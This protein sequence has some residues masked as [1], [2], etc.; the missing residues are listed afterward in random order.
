[1]GLDLARLILVGLLESRLDIS[2]ALYQRFEFSNPS[3]QEAQVDDT[4]LERIASVPQLLVILDLT[5]VHLV[6]AFKVGPQ[7]VN[8]VEVNLL[9]CLQVT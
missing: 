2:Q 9:L 6:D 3:L 7:K 4:L 8:F 1:V 5:L